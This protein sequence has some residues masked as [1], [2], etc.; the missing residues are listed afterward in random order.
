MTL[1]QLTSYASAFYLA[2]ATAV[3][4]PSVGPANAATAVRIDTV[5]DRY[6]LQSFS[7]EVSPETGKAEIRLQ[8]DYPLARIAGNDSEQ[9]PDPKVTALPGLR[10][11]E[12]VHAIV[13]DDGATHTTC[14]TASRDNLHMRR[15]G[16]CFVFTRRAGAGGVSNTLDTWFE[17]RR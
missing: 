7:F 2:V 15:T 10:Y 9:A 3:A 6:E 11:D 17:V 14:A 13:Y 16:A 8:Y 12:A 4:A 5:A 1:R